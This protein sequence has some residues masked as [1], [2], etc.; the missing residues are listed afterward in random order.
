MLRFAKKIGKKFAFIRE[1]VAYACDVFNDGPD[2]SKS[3]KI[4]GS[5]LPSLKLIGMWGS[6]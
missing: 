3:F 1:S 4:E 2:A 5:G 6:G